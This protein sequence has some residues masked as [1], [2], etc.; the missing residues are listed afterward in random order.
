MG[1]AIFWI[2]FYHMP[3]VPRA[4][5]LDFIHEIGFIGVDVFIFMSGIG[6]GHS[7]KRRGREGYLLQRAKRIL[8]GLIPVLVIWSLA[9]YFGGALTLKEFFGSV[10]LLGCWMGQSTQLNWYFSTIWM[11]YLL[12]AMLYRP[13]CEG[14]HPVLTALVV[15]G[16]S[17]LALILSSNPYSGIMY[18]RI[19]VF[20]LGMLMGRAEQD[21]VP[22]EKLLRTV[23]YG[24]FPVGIL[25]VLLVYFRWG[26]V[27]G[28]SYGLWWYPFLLV[29][30]G[31]I[32]LVCDLAHKLR[33]Y[34]P[35]SRICRIFEVLGNNSI[36]I[37]IV[38]TA[39]F[40]FIDEFWKLYPWQW[41]MLM[42]FCLIL[43]IGYR[44]VIQKYFP[45]QV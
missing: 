18:A 32:F 36:E 35:F 20:L 26:T 37:L 4:P 23:L 30:P 43:G 42:F 40:K 24:L 15:S 10:S 21:H 9:M 22:P 7:V 29:V 12:G 13:V 6:V 31:G 1:L 2:V 8:P 34:Q 25:V 16:Y 28:Y 33:R 17:F 5:W 27:Y 11:F 41:L 14:K 39:I 45:V 38:Q 19:P 3:W 44:R